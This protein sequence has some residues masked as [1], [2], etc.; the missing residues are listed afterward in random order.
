M[1]GDPEVIE[2][3]NE[4][5][6]AE[7]TAINQYFLHAKMQENFGWTKLAKYTR[8]ESFDEMKHAEILTDRILFLDGLPNYQRLFHV[9]VGQTVK[10]MFE[11]DRQVEVEAIDRLKRGI[12][13]MRNKGDITSAN[14]FESILADEEHHIDYLD[15]QLELL[16]KLGEALYIAQLIEQPES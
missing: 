15:T 9:R 2:F 16:E 14:I 7:L 13:V 5:L 4:Q 12:E 3:L 11:A 1:Q 10:E 8:H 6:T